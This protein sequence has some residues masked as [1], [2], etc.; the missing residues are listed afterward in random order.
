MWAYVEPFFLPFLQNKGNL[1]SLSEH[2]ESTENSLY[3]ISYFYRLFLS[4]Y[5]KKYQEADAEENDPQDG[6]DGDVLRDNDNNNVN[7]FFVGKV[8]NKIWN[9][10]F[11]WQFARALI[12]SL[13]RCATF[14]AS[15]RVMPLKTF[16]CFD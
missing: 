12:Q 7:R 13:W 1:Q 16:W 5:T 8:S 9:I 10:S 14:D 11:C 6:Y 3:K 4:H 2:R 15:F